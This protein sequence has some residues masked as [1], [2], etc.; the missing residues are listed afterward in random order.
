MT[1]EE[2]TA[3]CARNGV[4]PDDVRD[5]RRKNGNA[6]AV[7]A[8]RAEAICTCGREGMSYQ[9]TRALVGGTRYTIQ[10]VLDA[11][12]LPRPER[13]AD[14][15]RRLPVT[16]TGHMLPVAGERDETCA[17]YR[18]CLGACLKAHPVEHASCPAPVR[19]GGPSACG[20]RV[21]AAQPRATEFL[22]VNGQARGA[23]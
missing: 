4:D 18:D 7:V 9:Q 2:F 20:H 23:A 14:K 19:K 10:R 5:R 6:R 1:S 22:S 15:K 21:A 3:L 13:G 16:N 12:N 17:L 8:T 11:A